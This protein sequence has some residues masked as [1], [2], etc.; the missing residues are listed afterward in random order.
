MSKSNTSRNDQEI[1]WSEQ[2]A[3]DYIKKNAE[4]DTGLAL[5]AW[6]KMLASTSGITSLLECGCNIGRNIDSLERVLPSASKSIIEISKPAFDFVS[7][8]YALAQKF[9]GS[10]LESSLEGSFDLVYTMGVLIHINPDELLANLQK[11]YNYSNKYLLFGE[12]FNRT[13]T[14]IEYQGQKNR[15]FKRDFGK[16]VIENFSVKLLDYGFLWG[17]IYDAA[18]FDDITWWMFEKK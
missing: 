8:R 6:E 16:L 7:R 15:L 5:E 12:Y 18:G 10:I 3:E 1:F 4:F 17:H 2:Y 13:P 14:M 11:V 9:N